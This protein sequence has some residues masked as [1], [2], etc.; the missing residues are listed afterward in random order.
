MSIQWFP[1]HMTKALRMM[2]DNV[3]IVDAI[4][5]V[6]DARA[7]AACFNPSFEKIVGNKPCVFILN[8]CDLADNAK[9]DKW[10]AYLKQRGNKVVKVTATASAEAGKITSA[11]EEITI[12]LREKQRQKGVFK[13][14]RCLIL[15]VPNCG[16]STIIN[17]LS[18]RKTVI[19]GDKPGVT[20]G[21]QWVRLK[22]GLELLDTPGTLWPKF[23]EEKLAYELCFVGS[24]KDDVVDLTDVALH[25]I[26][27]LAQLYPQNLS[28]RY[29]IE[30]QGKTSQE[31]FDVIAQKRG[32]LLRGGEIDVERCSKAVLD[33][34]RK[35][36]MGKITL[37][38]PNE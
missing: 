28:D 12:P 13:P 21:K 35:G 8:K 22:T 5:Y 16:K 9:V 26:G 6:L 19:T 27:Q 1:G 15:G 18:G 29:K 2:Q 30:T 7:P 34:F 4:G 38:L 17:C 20:K 10:C 11:F 31:I 24:I 3:K 23:D 33:D 36:K 25:L 32:F 37:D 14:V